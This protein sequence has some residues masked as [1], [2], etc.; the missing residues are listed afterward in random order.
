MSLKWT[1]SP[2][3]GTWASVINQILFV[4]QIYEAVPE[5][6]L[7]SYK[8]IFADEVFAQI[9]PSIRFSLHSIMKAA[10]EEFY[11]HFQNAI[12]VVSSMK[13]TV[14]FLQEVANKV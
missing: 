2:L 5:N 9:Y 12:T 11:H 1:L 6:L 10:E 4:F 14:S 7:S 13:A 8:A 3:L